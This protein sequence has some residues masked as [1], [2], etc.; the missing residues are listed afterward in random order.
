MGHCGATL[1]KSGGKHGR[2]VKGQQQEP[3]HEPVH[4]DR[5]RHDKDKITTLEQRCEE[6]MRK[7]EQ[8]HKK[9]QR[10]SL[11][12]LGLARENF[13]C[14]GIIEELQLENA[15]LRARCNI[16][17]EDGEMGRGDLSNQTRLENDD[18]EVGSVVS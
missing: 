6:L 4:T 18:Q 17:K 16:Y 11:A 13:N 12:Y 9:L 2:K 1:K 3:S 7:V 10:V 8:E 15:S 5:H 14:Y